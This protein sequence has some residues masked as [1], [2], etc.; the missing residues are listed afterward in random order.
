M[1]MYVFIISIGSFATAHLFC[2][3]RLNSNILVVLTV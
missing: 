1:Y 2:I 3:Y